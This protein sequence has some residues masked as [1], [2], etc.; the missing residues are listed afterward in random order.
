MEVH[1][2]GAALD[3]A[4]TLPTLQVGAD[5]EISWADLAGLTPTER[6]RMKNRLHLRRK[7]AQ[8]TGNG[9]QE[10]TTRL[11]P[12]PHPRSHHRGWRA[13]GWPWRGRATPATPKTNLWARREEKESRT[14]T[15]DK[16]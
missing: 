13:G 11:E 14:A 6:R 5:D 12:G 1:E 7:R 16:S 10:N 3:A 15:K 2:A 4:A 9:I 8:A